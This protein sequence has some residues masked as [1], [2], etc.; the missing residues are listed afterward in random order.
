MFC[1]REQVDYGGRPILEG[2]DS[3]PV[4]TWAKE[5]GGYEQHAPPMRLL[6]N[7]KAHL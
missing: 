6:P 5:F 4:G 1:K 2:E 3:C 7:G